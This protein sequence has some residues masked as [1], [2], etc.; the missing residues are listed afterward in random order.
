MKLPLSVLVVVHTA[1]LDVL[2]LERAARPGF[3]Q[4]VTGSLDRSDE[5]FELAATREVR[6]ETGID[7]RSGRLSGWNVAYTFEI[8]PQ[9]RHRFAPGVTHNTERVFTLRLQERAPV[10]IAPKE[11]TAFAWLPWREAARKCF[12]W[13]NR[14]AILM[15]GAALVAAGCATGEAPLAP[16]LNAGASADVRECAQWYRTLDAEIEAAGVRD[17]QHTRVP[18]FPHLRVDRALASLK[19]RAAQS[20]GGLRAF[21]E[22]L[23]E[24]DAESRLHEVRNLPALNE[25]ARVAALR[26]ARDCGKRLSDA[27]L[28]SPGARES[29]LSAA[30]VPDD[31]STASRFFGLYY[32]T[33]IPFASGVHN[34][35]NETVAAF[36]RRR[37]PAANR[38]R[39]APPQGQQLP[40]SV[41]AGLLARAAFDPLGHPAVSERELERLALTYAPTL[42][43]EI[44]GDYDR[45]GVLRWRR[46]SGTTPEVDATEPTVYVQAAYT[47]YRDHL[48]LQLV[49]TLWFSERPPSGSFDLL[50]GRLD[51]VVWRVTLAPDGEPILY[52]SMHPC[53]CYHIFFPTPRARPRPTPDDLEEWAFIPRSV[54]TAGE[55]S[56]AVL[57]IASATHY[58][59]GIGFERGAESLVRYRF[60]RY[61]ELRS[62]P[63]PGGEHASAFSPQGLIAG[64]E[65]LERYFFWPMGIASAGAMRQWG[66]HATAFVGRRHFD[67]ADLLER[68]FELDL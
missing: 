66:R 45:F 33:R 48:L 62:L 17:A 34:W 37:D 35:Q 5:P 15:V 42:E 11:H 24:F 1:E 19:D 39:Y 50:A 58:I 57:T 36:E 43:V 44:G 40:R 18:G 67:D 49:Y 54:P 7:A 25:D 30:K 16:H 14:D 8:F 22:R 60:R 12:S 28:A 6:E 21:S 47:R 53:G 68:R 20:E 59:E 65:R 56:R 23:A 4:S 32:L 2:L 38:V 10:T 26:R 27:D 9:W 41:V 61:D 46:A 55:G 13:S 31:Y 52:D 51:G 64:T 63:R 29:L 3:W